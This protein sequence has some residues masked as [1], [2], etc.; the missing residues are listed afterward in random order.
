MKIKK[1]GN[2]KRLPGEFIDDMEKILGTRTKMGLMTYKDA[3]FT[4]AVK[5][6]RKTSGY[7]F[8]LE[9]L[10]TKPERKGK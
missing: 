8:S 2:T 4:K 5:L 10:R 6:L 9:E 1:N 7:K 3:K